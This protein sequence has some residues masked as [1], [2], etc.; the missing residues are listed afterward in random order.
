MPCWWPSWRISA[1]V[2]CRPPASVVNE[3]GDDEGQV[4]RGQ[5][6]VHPRLCALNPVAGVGRDQGSQPRPRLRC[7]HLYQWL[8]HVYD[9]TVGV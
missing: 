3:A 6:A 5:A 8:I 9:P 4:T 7:N 1:G 2:V